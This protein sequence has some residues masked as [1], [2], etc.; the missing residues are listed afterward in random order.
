MKTVAPIEATDGYDLMGKG[1]RQRFPAKIYFAVRPVNMMP[2]MA[3]TSF[4]PRL[5]NGLKHFASASGPH[6]D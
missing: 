4:V 1:Q 3:L 5:K 2:R 6:A